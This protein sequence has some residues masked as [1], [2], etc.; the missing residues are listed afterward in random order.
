[1]ASRGLD[2][3][4]VAYVMNYDLPTNIESYIHR[5]GRTGRIGKTG[6]SVSFVSDFDEPMYNKLYGVLK[7]SN[8]QIPDWFQELIHSKYQREERGPMQNRSGKPYHH[9]WRGGYKGGQGG[10]G[11]GNSFYSGGGGGRGGFSRNDDDQGYDSD[12]SRPQTTSYGNRGGYAGQSGFAPQTGTYGQ[13][14]YGYE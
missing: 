10:Q 9:K 5:I 12:Y 14:S 11:G 3:P 7:D 1:M 6:T 8:Q 4:D 13:Q 2:I